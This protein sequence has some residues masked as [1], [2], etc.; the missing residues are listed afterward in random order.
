MMQSSRFGWARGARTASFASRAAI[1]VVLV[2]MLGT[3]LPVGARATHFTAALAPSAAAGGHPAPPTGSPALAPTP[4]GAGPAPTA[5]SGASAT[6]TPSGWAPHLAPSL[7]LPGPHPAAWGTQ[8]VP[9]GGE[10]LLPLYARAASPHPAASGGSTAAWN[11]RFCNGIWPWAINDSTSESYYAG[12][13]YGHDEPGMEFYSGLNGSG[14][15][16][17][18]NVTL[19]VDRS[20]TQNQSDLYSAIWFGMT[21]TDP[22]AWMD[23]CFLELQFYPDQLWTNPGPVYPNWTVN[24][25]WIGLA[26]AWQIE[27]ATGSENPCFYQP[28]RLGSAT[29]GPSYFN[30]TQ[31]DRI[32]VTM[33]GWPGSTAGE[34]IAIQ[35]VTQGTNSSVVLYDR[36]GNFPLN[37]SYTSNSYENGLQ[38]T[39]GGEYPVVF[40]FETGHAG[41]PVYPQNNSY[42]GCSPGIPPS[43]PATPS[44]PCP[45]YDP[46]S[47][48]NDSLY[49]WHFSPATFFNASGSWA[50]AQVA[51]TQD[52]GGIA[53]LTDPTIGAT[54]CGGAAGSA[55]CSF[56]WYSYSCSARAFEFGA[57]DYA[58]VSDD[59]GQYL[60]YSQV[61]EFNGLGFGF[62]PPT[63]FSIPTCGGP[64]GSLTVA[65]SSGSGGA[66][67]FLSTAVYGPTTFASLA[68][69]E[70]SIRAYSP[71]GLGFD[72]W[73]TTGSVAIL[74]DPLSPW[75]DV[76]VTG[77]GGGTVTA[78]FGPPL[79]T[80]VQF[81][82]LGTT[83]PGHVILTPQRLYTDGVPLATLANG[84]SIDLAPGI[85]GVLALPSPGSNFTG[86]SAQSP[87]LSVAPVAFPYAWLTVTPRGGSATLT[88]HYAPTASLATVSLFVA[89]NGTATF[90][91][92]STTASLLTTVAAGTY[93]LNSTPATG[94]AFGGL[95]YGPSAVTTDFT[96][97]TNVTVENGSSFLEV[98]FN[99]VP[100]FANL[101]LLD[102]LNAPG[103][104]GAISVDGG[105]S[106]APNGTVASVLVGSGAIA[107]A[108][109]AGDNFTSWSVNNTSAV[110][111]QQPGQSVAAIV[112]N[113]SATITAHY[114]PKAVATVSFF[115]R[116]SGGGLV[117]FNGVA[118]ADG[119]SNASV[120]NGTYL[121]EALPTFGFSSAVSWVVNGSG[122][123]VTTPL[124]VAVRLNGT[125][126][127]TAIFSALPVPTYPVTFVAT[128]PSGPSATLGAAALSSG[129]TV[130]LAA[131]QYNLSVAL[132][133]N[134]TFETWEASPGLSVAGPGTGS[135][136]V[137][138]AGPGTLTAVVAPFSVGIAASPNPTD[139]G[140]AFTL[141][142]SV[143]GSGTFSYRWAL[144]AGCPS[145][146]AS[147]IVC[148]LTS[149]GLVV[150]GLTVTETH[151]VFAAAP[152]VNLTVN[153]PL[154]PVVTL[155][156]ST[157]DLGMATQVAVNV[158]GGT[159]P[160]S[161]SFGALPPGCTGSSALFSCT[162]LA[163]GPAAVIV[164]VTDALGVTQNGFAALVVNP[165]P[166][167]AAFTSSRAVTDV[168][169]ATTLS[170]TV[171]G[172][173]APFA[174]TYAGL[175]T[176]C[177]T[178]SAASLSCTPSAAGPA[179][180]RVNVTDLY[181][182][183]ATETVAFT[184]H[185]APTVDALTA[186]VATLDVG[187]TT[188]LTAAGGN[189]TAPLAYT[190]SG[191]PGGCAASPAA[192]LACTPTDAGTATVVLTVTDALGAAAQRSIPVTV[193][194]RPAIASVVLSSD[195]IDLGASVT[196][197]VAAS[198]G[199]GGLGVSF[200][201]LPAGCT[202]ANTT[203]LTCTPTASGSFAIGARA[204]D[205][206]GKA[207][208]GNVTLTVIAPSTPFLATT[209]GYLTLG[210]IALAIVIVA[211]AVLLL[212]RRRAGS[213]PPK[214]WVPPAS[215][216]GTSTGAGTG[217]PPPVEPPRP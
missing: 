158:S 147:S 29:S 9:P 187:M 21:L 94:W 73:S 85:Y 34:G 180:V 209:T 208:Y 33:T 13:C 109:F 215:E 112:V 90:N 31:G 136:T 114:L 186:S 124:G 151:G 132:P 162:P 166:T 159:A 1:V 8:A 80:S 129:D 68:L 14:G 153:G 126:A 91:G 183:T 18:W 89:G 198:G 66:V 127:I 108:P 53:I 83:V 203:A 32:S 49:P 110:W 130:W 104:G 115:A 99:P 184:V 216:A 37:P 101:T 135:T 185:P 20:A 133:G 27:A 144:P 42:G 172:G 145:L 76:E 173:T 100:V 82:D 106:Y 55:Y 15:N 146:N 155:T 81:V 64:S 88:A 69:G 175:P 161:Y 179:V 202:S 84:S 213:R 149:P 157:I 71:A 46:G 70:Y 169:V 134:Q 154:G 92:L 47:W 86:W 87:Q 63:N 98:V 148:T 119:S 72:G 131:G 214:A 182:F 176:G 107:A 60:E 16:V 210:L 17:T 137:T 10:A 38:W 191:L 171:A 28:L 199:T 116:P 54:T 197:T 35:D 165:D 5:H 139:V 40:A 75:A 204:T 190:W 7:S 59:F 163:A 125:T 61:L 26:V 142:A 52:F 65:P 200:T 79:T 3:G 194:A 170:V 177:A 77:T 50:P 19:P 120:A 117:R 95:F 128:T 207:G 121:V 164:N 74:G 58:G 25:R 192:Q 206:L 41:N 51:F 93:P 113:A 97:T 205:A 201:G 168:G 111:I 11:N 196:V 6:P 195:T 189:G 56:P 152:A 181:G 105:A 48:A 167:I 138:V 44:V 2:L 78:D 160:Y 4:G 43:T 118:Y 150:L 178:A 188:V 211:A 193:N 24:G 30:M 217:A 36:A 23:Q 140:V 62:F 141:T 143:V 57:T 212:R 12:D 96:S 45:S 102:F 174:Y 122:R 39:P 67:Y 22:L 123:L 103:A 156:P